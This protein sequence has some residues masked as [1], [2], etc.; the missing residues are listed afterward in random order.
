[1]TVPE[2]VATVKITKQQALRLVDSLTP[3]EAAVVDVLLDV[4]VATLDQLGLAV[5]T[6][7]TEHDRAIVAGR[8][9]AK[10]ERL[11]FILR[12]PIDVRGSKRQVAFPLSNG[13]VAAATCD[14]PG[15]PVRRRERRDARLV[16]S[17]VLG[18]AL[19]VS[20]IY[21]AFAACREH[22]RLVIWQH[23]EEI[24]A[25]SSGG[26]L[27]R[28]RPD[29]YAVWQWHTGEEQ[30]FFLE[31]ERRPRR[32]ETSEKV[33]QYYRYW[34]GGAYF[35]REDSRIFP[36][37][38]FITPD[39]A[40]VRTCLQAFGWAT[41]PGNIRE[42]FRPSVTSADHIAVEGILSQIWYGG[43]EVVSFVDTVPASAA[44]KHQSR[45]Y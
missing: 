9:V 33:Q 31:Y 35:R 2:A 36:G 42:Y 40:R 12:H 5:S 24:I 11:G 20:G 43:P 13:A 1:M 29:A 22:G 18:H 16:N 25:F 26:S 38:L 21:A 39:V 3:Y 7:A 37:L 44:P 8:A 19:G 17:R 45:G 30:R 14:R 28:I 34:D 10:L 6:A 23:D 4:H 27:R 15:D 32:L 41:M